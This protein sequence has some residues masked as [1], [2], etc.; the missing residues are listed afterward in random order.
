MLELSFF[1]SVAIAL[2]FRQ[3]VDIAEHP[4][5][6]EY[7]KIYRGVHNFKDTISRLLEDKGM[8]SLS[9]FLPLSPSHQWFGKICCYATF[10]LGLCFP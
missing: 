6:Q 9:P 1:A 10:F 8:D 4:V 7:L 3:S 2:I 5:V